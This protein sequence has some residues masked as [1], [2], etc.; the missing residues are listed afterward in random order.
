MSDDQVTAPMGGDNA[1]PMGGSDQQVSL[2]QLNKPV[3]PDELQSGNDAAVAQQLGLVKQKNSELLGKNKALVNDLK[4]LRD[5]FE[6]LKS[7]QQ[8]AAQKNL[9]DQGAFRELYEQEKARAKTLEARLLSET[10]ELK[11]QLSQVQESAKQERLRASATAQISKAAAVNP[12][13]LYK[14]LES[15][16]RDGEDGSPVVLNDGVEQPLGD[17]LANLRQSTEWA[18]HFS[19]SGAV[20]MGA[21]SVKSVAPGMSNP[22]RDGNLTEAM[23]LEASNPELAKAL[24]AEALRG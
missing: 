23:M 15:Q 21:A 20:G 17:Y 10:G 1:A 6:S 11:A 3:R 5:E 7:A 22:Y 24:K 9:E 14:L 16:L 8:Q 18:H 12:T 19:A 4:S 13:Q 2:E